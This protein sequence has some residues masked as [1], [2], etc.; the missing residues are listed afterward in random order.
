MKIAR[1]TN[2]IAIPTA[3]RVN[4]LVP[5]CRPARGWFVGWFGSLEFLT[6]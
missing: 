2:P 3:S 5:L 6:I 4:F 1:R